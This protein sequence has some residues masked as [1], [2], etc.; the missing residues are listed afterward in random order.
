MLVKGAN[1]LNNYDMHIE[2]FL[3]RKAFFTMKDI[4]HIFVH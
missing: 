4:W 3:F 1:G 2:C